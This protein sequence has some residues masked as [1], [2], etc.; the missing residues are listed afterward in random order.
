MR[1]QSSSKARPNRT[2]LRTRNR[3]QDDVIQI[4]ASAETKSILNR[5]ATLRGHKLSEFVL[6]SARR[7]AEETF[8][9]QQN[10]FLDP[11]DHENFFEMLDRPA[12]STAELCALLGRRPSWEQ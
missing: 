4:R 7:Q 3:P 12:K 11:K 6:D 2:A 8:L 10:F 1:D 9:D 5:A